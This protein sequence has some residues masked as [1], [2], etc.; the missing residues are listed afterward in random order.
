MVGLLVLLAVLLLWLYTRNYLHLLF[1]ALQYQFNLL[2]SKSLPYLPLNIVGREVEVREITDLLDF[3]NSQYQVISIIGPP[4]FGKS[5]LAIHIGHNVVYEGVTVHYVDMIEVSSMQSLAEKVLYSDD[6]I[7]EIRNIT[8][9]RL[10]KWA[11]QRHY[12]TLL[13]FDNC[14]DMFHKQKDEFQRVLKQLIQSSQNVK[15]LMTSRHKTAQ[16]DQFPYVLQEISTKASCNL[17]QSIHNGI[18]STECESITNLTGKVPLALRIVGALLNFPDSP[19]L[20]I[21]LASL[22]KE[23]ISTLSSEIFPVEERVNASISLSYRYLTPQLQEIGRYLAHFP[24]SFDQE[25]A[26]DIMIHTTSN[27]VMCSDA[28]FL[29]YLS[30]RS[31]L[32]Y[33]QRQRRYQF[34][35]LIRE[36]FLNFVKSSGEAGKHETKRFL[37]N[38]Q[39]HYTS[40]LQSLVFDQFSTSYKTAL[41]ALEK[42]RHNI[43]YLLW[44]TAESEIYWYALYTISI[45]LNRMFLNCRFTANELL[46]PVKGI[47]NHLHQGLDAL[48]CKEQEP[49]YIQLYFELYVHFIDEFAKLEVQ[50]NGVSAAIKIFL[51]SEHIVKLTSDHVAVPELYILFYAKLSGYYSILEEYENVKQCHEKILKSTKKLAECNEEIGTCQYRTIGTAYY[52]IE[53]YEKAA[54]F[55]QL[56][57]ELESKKL[58]TMEMT[59][60]MIKLYKSYKRINNEIKA[61]AT[62]QK[63]YA[64]FPS[65][66]DAPIP[67]LHQYSWVL[68]DLIELYRENSDIN[69]ATKLIERLIEVLQTIDPQPTIS[70]L[71][72][73][74]ALAKYLTNGVQNY[75]KA[76]ELA[77]FVLRSFTHLD[78]DQQEQL[79]WLK[80]DIHLVIGFSNWNSGNFSEGLVYLELGANL[81]YEQNVTEKFNDAL[82]QICPLL[83]FRGRFGCTSVSE[84]LTSFTLLAKRLAS[85]I[86][87]LLFNGLLDIQF[88]TDS[89]EPNPTQTLHAQVTQISHS[90]DIAVTTG[91]ASIIL[92]LLSKVSYS[93]LSF[94][95]SV[96]MSAAVIAATAVT[97]T[98][99]WILSFIIV[100]VVINVL[101][102]WMK[103]TVAYLLMIVIRFLISA[104]KIPIFVTTSRYKFY[105]FI[106]Y[107]RTYDIR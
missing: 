43:Q 95:L 32:E 73:A 47:V 76:T 26:C 62:L 88:D 99:L 11:R 59:E 14:D 54:Y 50:V 69:N 94:L 77:Q 5:T 44:Y 71:E 38:F 61:E 13:I 97:S 86:I 65:V 107:C 22:E 75:L 56:A 46:L 74:N 41:A 80:I 49:L 104:S 19:D 30:E 18:N 78:K 36:F 37:T 83:V 12:R 101:W 106:Y 87:R 60:L 6:N 105:V 24:G 52:S 64:L 103:L 53:D 92:I 8:V 98:V 7:V 20:S 81:I 29:T 102:I 48:L 27:P 79:Q 2:H 23:L 33:S 16:L 31:L 10:F 58:N 1:Y 68:Q 9:D 85:F 35:R 72:K 34:H 17:L 57:L 55:F 89:H 90:K 4:G 51:D 67:E 45:A 63:I 28:D 40:Q 93:L 96:F 39:W 25:A 42:E 21:I 3:S 15:I 70:T 100:R 66:M 82:W 84:K 91:D